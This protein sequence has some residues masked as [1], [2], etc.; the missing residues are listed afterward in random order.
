MHGKIASKTTYP[1]S[2]DPALF[3]APP[4]MNSKY[5]RIAKLKAIGKVFYANPS[6]SKKS[7]EPTFTSKTTYAYSTPGQKIASLVYDDVTGKMT[8]SMLSPGTE[9]DITILTSNV[10]EKST[11]FSI[12]VD[13]N[14]SLP[15]VITVGFGASLSM[16][17]NL[18][19]QHI[20]S[21]VVN[22]KSYLMS[23]TTINDGVIQTTENLAFD[24][25]TGDPVMTRTF[26]GYM[27]PQEKIY[28][29]NS[30][31]NKHQGYYYSLNIPASWVY[32][33]MAPI[34]Y[35]A[36]NTNQLGLMAG[37]VV[38]YS[39]NTMYN[40]IL[41]PTVV[42]TQW[43]PFSN[44]LTN[45]VN[46]SS[47]V[48]SNNWFT[49]GMNTDYPGISSVLTD[50]NKHF[51]PERS[52][53]YRT[54]ATDAN[55]SSVKIYT[56]GL[57][58]GSFNF[59]KWGN[60]TSSGAEWYS[61]SRVTKYSPYGY[62]IEEEDALLIKSSA[63]FGYNNTLPVIVAQNA[64][65]DETRFVDFE[66]GSF[67]NTY[68]SKTSA[69]SGMSSYIL[70]SDP[71]YAVATAYPIDV[72]KGI[73]VKLWLKSVLNTASNNVNYNLKN[74]NP[75]LKAKIGGQLFDF[76]AIASTGEWTLYS[77][78]IKN[79]NTLINGNYNIQLG[80]N[81]AQNELVYI[82]DF[83]VQP[84]EASMNC[85]VY[86]P[87]NKLAAQFDDQHFG[88]FYE[89]NNMGQLVRKSI[90]TERGK[91]TLQEQQYNTPLIVR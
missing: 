36:T 74:Q 24:K 16:S 80:Y 83:R 85:S 68:I 1:G 33:K 90:E 87:D 25:Y 31:A 51:Y 66:Y 35:T 63:K 56:G 54:T 4:V 26:D 14:I 45:V 59:F 81:F 67:T 50:V 8:K 47:T 73:S 76:K 39:T 72:Q 79:Y 89:Y 11:D 29:I 22:K 91:K 78:D 10:H 32:P 55:S 15:V 62:P 3:S 12:E 43:S 2:Y 64:M 88:V 5:N 70:S 17:D 49:A 46:A 6:D 58:T 20:T 44:P 57:A 82:D 65:Q 52:Y 21:K 84:L 9:E 53:S 40:T 37:N 27:A 75:L 41:N 13:I 19:C 38:T 34:T 28:T 23:T 60:P 7:T 48:Y 61:D 69:H 30:T 42:A 71:N 77:A 86:N 18:L